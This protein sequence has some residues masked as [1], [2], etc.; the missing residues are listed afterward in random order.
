MTHDIIS[1]SVCAI[2][3]LSSIRGNCTCWHHTY[4]SIHLP[5]E[6]NPEE[7]HGGSPLIWKQTEGVV[8]LRD[9]KDSRK[10]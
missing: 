9:E 10:P 6:L 1:V 7:S 8:Q 2:A 5:S 3:D 4:A